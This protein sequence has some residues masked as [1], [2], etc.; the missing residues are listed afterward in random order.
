MEESLETIG[1]KSLLDLMIPG[2]HNSAS[3]GAFELKDNNFLDKYT[4]CQ[5][6]NVWNQLIYGIRYNLVIMLSIGSTSAYGQH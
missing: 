1:E 6:E 4:L 5:D 2:T 3:F